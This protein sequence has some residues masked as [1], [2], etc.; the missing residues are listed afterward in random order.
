MHKSVPPVKD[1]KGWT[2]MQCDPDKPGHLSERDASLTALHRNA[3]AVL[4]YT[5]ALPVTLA[6]WLRTKP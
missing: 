6:A 5:V 3:L 2:E 4:S 1:Y